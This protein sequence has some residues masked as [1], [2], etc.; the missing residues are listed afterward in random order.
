M[1]PRI[2]ED[3]GEGGR[4]RGT[5]LRVLVGMT[6]GNDDGSPPPSSR[7]QAIREDTGERGLV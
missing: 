4:P 2:R 5:P 3:T 6:G 1:G 7:G